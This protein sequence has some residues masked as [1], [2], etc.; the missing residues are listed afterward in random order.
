MSSPGITPQ[1]PEAEGAAA[2]RKL[3]TGGFSQQEADQWKQ[4]QTATLQK[5]GFKPDEIAN[6]WGDRQPN[7]GPL[8]RVV[9]GGANAAGDPT[10]SQGIWGDILAGANHSV[11]GQLFTTLGLSN[12]PVT[13]ARDSVEG[14]AISQG[15]QFVGDYPAY[16]AGAVLTKSPAGTFAL[17][18]AVREAIRVYNEKGSINNLSDLW[19]QIAPSIERTAAQGAIGW[20]MGPLGSLGEGVA[21]KI[22]QSPLMQKAGGLVTQWLGMTAGNSAAEGHI[23][24]YKEFLGGAI[25]VLG[26]GAAGHIAP[27]E[28]PDSV[29]RVASNLQRV[30]TERGINPDDAIRRAQSDPIWKQEIMGQDAHGEPVHPT[31]NRNGPQEAPPTHQPPQPENNPFSAA[32]E[33]KRVQTGFAA[34]PMHPGD[35]SRGAHVAASPEALMPL[36]R[37]LE[38]SGDSAISP[39]GAIGRF[40]IMPATARQ[41]GFDPTRLKDPAYNEMVAKHILTDLHNRYGGNVDDILVAYNAGPGRANHWINQGRNLHD[42]PLET[43]KYLL[44]SD[45]LNGWGSGG[46]VGEPNSGSKNVAPP[47]GAG[48]EPPEGGATAGR[49]RAGGEV[50]PDRLSAES[51][52]DIMHD[53]IGEPAKPVSAWNIDTMYRQ[54]VSELGPA[55]S[56]D[57]LLNA[58]GMTKPTDTRMNTEDMFRQTYGSAQRAGHFVKY[59]TLDP[60]AVDRNGGNLMV[61][62]TSDDSFVKAYALAAERGGMAKGFD[63]YRIA[64]RTVEK[65]GQGI[66]IGPDAMK[67]GA[68]V[69]KT[70]KIYGPASAMINRVKN[71]SLD[72]ARDSGVFSPEQT[73]IIKKYNEHHVAFRRIMG[74]DE[75]PLQAAR[76]R[77]FRASDPTKIMEGSDRKIID[78][79]TADID[80]LHNI[81]KMADRNRAIG[82]V[83]GA[84]E[85]HDGLGDALEIK[86]LPAPEAKAMLAE[87]GSDVFKSY[88]IDGKDQK[89]FQPFIAARALKGA[90]DGDKFVFFRNGKPEVWQAKDPDFAALMRGAD[91]KPQMDFFTKMA[92]FLAKTQRSGITLSPDYASRIT[93]RHQLTAAIFDRNGGIPFSDVMRGFTHVVKQ[94]DAYQRWVANGGAGTALVD[95]DTNYIKRDISRVMD[96]DTNT[97]NRMWNVVRHPIEFSQLISERMD[98]MARTGY[99]LR[100]EQQL[101]SLKAATGGRKAYLDYTERG[102]SAFANWMAQTTPFMRPHIIGLKQAYEGFTQRPLRTSMKAAMFVTLPTV[103][104]YILNHLQDKYG[105]LPDDQ[106][107]ENLPRWQKDTLFIAPSIGGV[108]LRLMTPPVVGPIFGGMVN[109][110]LDHLVNEDPHA[111]EDW[112][113][114]VLAEFLPPIIPQI[115]LPM[116]EAYSNYSYFSQKPLIPASMENNSGPMQYTENTTAPAKLLGKVLG[117]VGVSTPMHLDSPIVL[118]NFVKE[119]AGTGGMAALK[120]LNAPLSDNGAPWQVADIPFVQSFVV[121]NPGMGAEPIQNFYDMLGKFRMAHADL[122]TAMDRAATTGDTS[123]LQSTVSNPEAYVNLVSVEH[124]LKMQHQTIIAVNHNDKMTDD[125]KRQFIDNAYSSMIHTSQFGLQ[126]MDAIDKG[127]AGGAP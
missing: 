89:A 56:V 93:A 83:V 59:G 81:I 39:A 100:T 66:N 102:T 11:V 48:G 30:W 55:M 43:Q 107:Y 114:S 42:L 119:W 10:Q 117:S 82:H 98:A 6:Y 27:G 63:A 123:E 104:L 71:A 121:R 79:V 47:G 57:R 61:G 13:K 28:L 2:Y 112:G 75:A 113:K 127:G 25:V 90:S 94:D 18:Q 23:P 16:F 122:A 31:M 96:T 36:V 103:G 51:L 58:E 74:D 72:Y 85:A 38:S 19:D 21:G 91:A 32:A 80:N 92:T 116:H 14:Q 12:N 50:P 120:A 53:Q 20:A 17:P 44:H 60:L 111:F 34:N 99:M 109:R 77:G 108:R 118:E 41:Y 49:E 33:I 73:D 125:E 5:G 15:T 46:G 35:E 24:T 64:K 37:S 106:K 29:K 3:L 40:Q 54:Y 65:A 69:G 84:I 115:A 62:K 87:P 7:T 22:T 9:A 97:M 86:K 110:F 126:M 45:K 101:G 67:A 88:G 4:Q 8:D 76:G 52:E 105:G 124:A 1:P 68:L 70:E 78:P 95:M 26:L